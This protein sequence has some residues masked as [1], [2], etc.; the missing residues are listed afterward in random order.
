M[1]P[2]NAVLFVEQDPSRRAVLGEEL[3]R[4]GCQVTIADGLQSALRY[5]R[6]TEFEGAVVSLDLPGDDSWTCLEEV[7]S[8]NEALSVIATTQRNHTP[9]VVRAIRMGV[10]DVTEHPIKAS[11]ILDGLR[12]SRKLK[13]LGLVS[14]TEILGSSPHAARL[15]GQISQMAQSGASPVLIQGESGTGRSFVARSLHRHGIHRGMSLS[16][17]DCATTPE[18]LIQREFLGGRLPE[19]RCLL[20]QNI[21]QLPR[22]VQ[23]RLVDLLLDQS[24]EDPYVTV[25]ATSD[26]DLSRKVADGRFRRDL[27]FLLTGYLVVVPPLRERKEDVAVLARAFVQGI[28]ASLGQTPASVSP[29]AIERLMAHDWP[30]N[31]AELKGVCD[32]AMVLALGGVVEAEHLVINAP[33]SL[34]ASEPQQSSVHLSLSDWSLRGMERTLIDAVLKKTGHNI[35]RAARELGI[36]R[37]TLYNKMREYRIGKMRSV[38]R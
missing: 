29:E 31:V 28:S 17:V 30:G 10:R 1:P 8:R 35:T 19:G 2:V 32:Y 14:P 36:N 18:G 13:N 23:K 34:E 20:I 21:E 7:F 9:S 33:L 5:L 15:R 6:H 27:Y 37:S 3:R 26:M 24:A 11:R 22:G 25:I 16:V 4:L 12:R 38:V